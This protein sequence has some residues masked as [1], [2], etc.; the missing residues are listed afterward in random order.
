MSKKLKLSIPEPCHEEW[1]GMSP[2]AQGRFCGSC[3]KEVI[4]FSTM[5]T[6][7]ILA[8]FKQ[9]K[10][11]VCGRFDRE[12]LAED[13]V[14][15]TKRIPWL[16]YFFQFTFPAFLL[17]C[18]SG[19]QTGKVVPKEETFY[20]TTGV[21]VVDFKEDP[22]V[23][24]NTVAAMGTP[25]ILAIDSAVST[26]QGD[27]EIITNM[28]TTIAEAQSDTI[29]LPEVVVTSGATI[30]CRRFL[31]GD[32]AYSQPRTISD[33]IK[34]IVATVADTFNTKQFKLFPNPASHGSVVKVDWNGGKAGTYQM[35]LI[36]M[37]GQVL[38]DQMIV[39]DKSNSIFPVDLPPLSPGTY[40]LGFASPQSKKLLSQKLLIR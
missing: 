9:P 10:G 40:L 30:T 36:N 18:K 33:T 34:T 17:S 4:D 37:A 6:A 25:A 31:S 22:I 15:P 35:Q 19:W 20:T 28:D 23:K 26:L 13:L 14:I 12:Q 21:M 27:V 32:I 16:R 3:Q 2:S 7:Q 11:A 29:T 39:I 24:E 1:E 5:S 38:T 8:F